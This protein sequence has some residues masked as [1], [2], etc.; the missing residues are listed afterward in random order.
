MGSLSVS[1]ACVFVSFIFTLF[2]HPFPCTL[3]PFSPVLSAVLCAFR[4]TVLRPRLTSAC[5]HVCSCAY[6]VK[7][8]FYNHTRG[9]LGKMKATRGR[10]ESFFVRH[11]YPVLLS[12]KRESIVRVKSQ[13]C[14]CL[15]DLNYLYR[16]TTK[17]SAAKIEIILYFT[18]SESTV[19]E[20]CESENVDH[21]GAI[22]SW[23]VIQFW[24][25]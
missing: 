23:T 24:K 2:Q 22:K 21:S 8:T 16:E 20:I 4:K 10:T 12:A 6:A 15:A 19:A 13:G 9:L 5:K 18:I 25:W 1:C 3:H 7:G 11:E 14:H 17:W